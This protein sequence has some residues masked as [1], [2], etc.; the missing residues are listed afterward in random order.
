MGV[1]TQRIIAGIFALC[2]IGACSAAYVASAPRNAPREALITVPTDAS[3]A[4]FARTLKEERIIRSETAFRVLARISGA[5]HRLNPGQ[6]LFEKPANLFTV[7]YRIS[8]AEHGISPVRVTLTE[9]MTA[10]DMAGTLQAQLPGF[11]SQAFLAEASTSEGYLFPETYLFMPGDAPAAIVS[12][13]RAQ[14]DDSA[15]AISPAV[16]ASG[17]SL[18][19]IVIM[20]SILEREANTPEDMQTVAGILW[21]RIKLGM[22]LQ[23]DAAFGYARQQNGYTPTAADLEGDSPYNT[24]RNKGL[25][26]TPIS[27]PGLAALRAAATPAK[28]SYLYYLTG[29]DGA[30]HYAQTFE[31]HK[32]NRELYL[33]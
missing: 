24:Y 27:N 22:P 11:D 6:Y 18:S 25:P 23:V 1:R 7:L 17:H 32:R 2:V 9:G 13:L 29:K 20:A 10:R 30:M 8:R 5:D 28:T 19:D 16:A 31:Q 4:Q 26:P 33:D 15:A 3:G 12:R 14:F 21:N